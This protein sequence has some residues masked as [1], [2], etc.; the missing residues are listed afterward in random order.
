MVFTKVNSKVVKVDVA[1]AG[2]VVART[3][4]MLLYTGD[5]AFS[6]HQ[7]PG[8]AQMGGMGGLMRIA[9]RM[10]QGEHERTMLAQGYGEVHYGY[11]GLDLHIVEIQP[12]AVLTVEA[13]RLLANT[14]GLQSAI[15][16]VAG[17]SGG[18][19]GGMMGMLRGAATGALTGQGMFTTQLSGHGA[20]VLL[21][22]GG[23]LELQV[24]GPA[25]VVVDPQ[26]FVGAYGNVTTEL[27]TAMS[28]RDAVGRGS[29]EAM[30]LNCQG[31]GTV[32]VQASEEKL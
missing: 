15:V 21:A 11:A 14:A 22:H 12:G 25:P 8:A 32:F 1:A 16:S 10:M 9:G 7:V 5:V 17:G 30:Q 24:G 31:Q 4:A 6:P 20:A 28:W 13:S 18:G 19:G 23:V 3:G 29:G 27:K 2:G 26:A